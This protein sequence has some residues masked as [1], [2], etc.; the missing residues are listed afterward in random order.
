MDMVENVQGMVIED[1]RKE[2]WGIPSFNGVIE[3][4]DIRRQKALMEMQ[5]KLGDDSARGIE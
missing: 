3:K 5:R 2:H 1:E 4:D